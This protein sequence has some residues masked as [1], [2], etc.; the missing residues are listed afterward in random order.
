MGN[1][2]SDMEY[3]KEVAMWQAQGPAIDGSKIKEY[4]IEYLNKTGH[5]YSRVH[6]SNTWNIDYAKFAQMTKIN[7]PSH[8]IW[9]KFTKKGHVVVVG[10]GNDINQEGE[11]SSALLKAAG[12][13]WDME[14]VFVIPIKGLKGKG[15]HQEERNAVERGIGDYLISKGVPIIDFYSHK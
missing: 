9:L 10:A 13:E 1:I 7:D 2:K 14:K 15:H 4:I 5:K 6:V 3:R 12:E 8:I 11:K